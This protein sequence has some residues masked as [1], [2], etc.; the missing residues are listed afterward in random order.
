MTMPPH[1][2]VNTPNP[3]MGVPNM[4]QMMFTPSVATVPTSMPPVAQKTRRHAIAIVDPA[5]NC[6]VKIIFFPCQLWSGKWL[7]GEHY[8][9]SQFISCN[10]Q[11]G[12]LS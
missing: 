9:R 4:Q 5:T 3:M 1:A 8:S 2:M 12:Q 11:V 6:Q 7:L 10:I